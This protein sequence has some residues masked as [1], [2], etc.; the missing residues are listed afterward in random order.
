MKRHCQECGV[1]FFG[2]RDKKFCSD[3]CRNTYNNRLNR[4]ETNFIRNVNYTLRKNRRILAELNPNGKTKIHR[5]K[6][7]QKGFNFQYFTNLYR[8]K[9]GNTYHFCYDQG[10]L[11]LED[12]YYA[13]VIR[14]KYVDQ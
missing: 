7:V 8:T 6:L 3:P 9:K 12:N 5:D 4:D 13:L 14:Q 11:E 1:E 10:Y 2:R